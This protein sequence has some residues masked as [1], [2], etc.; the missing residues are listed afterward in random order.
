MS[1]GPNAG[2]VTRSLAGLTGPQFAQS[3]E[4][5]Q[6]DSAGSLRARLG[7]VA[8]GQRPKRFRFPNAE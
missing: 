1:L 6:G 8:A 7:I 3:G 4:A 2:E 5:H